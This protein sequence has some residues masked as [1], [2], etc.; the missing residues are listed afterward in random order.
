MRPVIRRVRCDLDLIE[1]EDID[2][3]TRRV[4]TQL[5]TLGGREEDGF[6]V[7]EDYIDFGAI[8]RLID[9][10]ASRSSEELGMLLEV[11]WRSNERETA[12][13]VLLIAG[14]AEDPL[15]ELGEVCQDGLRTAAALE[16]LCNAKAGRTRHGL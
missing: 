9:G 8:A 2:A 15:S 3:A 13:T 4:R 1:G 14:Q 12:R 16:K 5:S 11:L 6:P 10:V 7:P